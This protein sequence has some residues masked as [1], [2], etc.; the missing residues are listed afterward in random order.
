MHPADAAQ[1]GGHG[2]GP[3]LAVAEGKPEVAAIGG[4]VDLPVVETPVCRRIL[5]E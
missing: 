2:K 1:V 4:V 5:A 3:G